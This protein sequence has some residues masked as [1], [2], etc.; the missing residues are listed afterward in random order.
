MIG[1]SVD[2]ETDHHQAGAPRTK[3]HLFEQA[4][5]QIHNRL[6]E[7]SLSSLTD[8][9]KAR[10]KFGT[11]FELL[12][13]QENRLQHPE[14]EK[15]KNIRL[16]IESMYLEAELILGTA[17]EKPRKPDGVSL[18]FDDQG[19][20]VI[21]KVIEFKST[22]KAF[23]QGIAKDQPQKSL[24]TIGDIVNLL[25]RLTGGEKTANLKPVD[26]DLSLDKRIKR[27]VRLQKVQKEIARTANSG[28]KIIYSPDLVY[29]II[30]PQG[31][32]LSQFDPDYL[33]K[34]HGSIIKMEVAKSSFSKKDIHRIVDDSANRQHNNRL[35][36]EAESLSR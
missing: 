22:Q 4:R 31:V 9:E 7:I 26:S 24:E 35:D 36:F 29:Q 30:I 33:I 27:D 11:V 15:Q 8:E 16:L 17:H 12:A 18:S 10:L 19:R 23:E 21:D 5:H 13:A 25:N 20:L 1:T 28:D 32:T 2:S 14:T 6:E 34:K 3:D